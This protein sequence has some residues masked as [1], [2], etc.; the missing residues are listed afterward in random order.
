[1]TKLQLLSVAQVA[2][3]QCGSQHWNSR[4]PN[5]SSSSTCPRPSW[6]ISTVPSPSGNG[7]GRDSGTD[8]SKPCSPCSV[9][10]DSSDAIGCNGWQSTSK[11]R[12]ERVAVRRTKPSSRA[13]KNSKE[14]R[15]SQCLGD[16]EAVATWLPWISRT[17]V[18][19]RIRLRWS[20]SRHALKTM[21]HKVPIRQWCQTKTT[22]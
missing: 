22:I 4:F 6:P 1:M 3:S 21:K 2:G 14:K 18:R 5:L 10:S 9:K 7:A 19:V 20:G 17:H 16:G 11:P 12:C 13:L 15:R 8:F